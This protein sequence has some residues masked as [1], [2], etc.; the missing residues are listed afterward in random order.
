MTILSPVLSLRWNQ[1]PELPERSASF[2]L[3]RRMQ[4]FHSLVQHRF[5]F[6]NA[7][8]ESFH[9]NLQNLRDVTAGEFVNVKEGERCSQI[10]LQGRVSQSKGVT[11]D[12]GEAIWCVAVKMM[13]K[14]A[15]GVLLGRSLHAQK[16][17]VE[18][19]EEPKRALR[20]NPTRVD[21]HF[22]TG[23]S[24]FRDL[25]CLAQASRHE[26]QKAEGRL[27]KIPD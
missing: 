15:D 18:S 25:R 8:L 9:R 5:P 20:G 27:M 22:S 16:H 24:H 3:L 21:G 11:V 19:G 13:V 4:E 1:T 14:Q 2:W 10:W 26:I 7:G 12:R 6:G 17:T 23:K